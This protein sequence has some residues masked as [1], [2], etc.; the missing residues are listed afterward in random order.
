MRGGLSLIRGPFTGKYEEEDF[1]KSVL[2]W[3]EGGLFFFYQ[4]SIHEET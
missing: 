1:G 4:G 3:G 2:K